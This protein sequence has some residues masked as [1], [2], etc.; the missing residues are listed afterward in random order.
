M[1]KTVYKGNDP[2]AI[3]C[4]AIANNAIFGF[5]WFYAAIL[6]KSKESIAKAMRVFVDP[7]NFP[8]LI[9]CVHGKD[10]TGLVVMLLLSLCGVPKVPIMTDYAESDRQLKKGKQAN[11]LQMAGEHCRF[12]HWRMYCSRVHG[13][14][15]ES[16][17]KCNTYPI[18]ATSIIVWFLQFK[19]SNVWPIQC[20]SM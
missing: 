7:C 4:P 20:G 5:K 10:R 6:D 15:I 19:L 18:P 11:E 12:M 14:I 16:W 8:I 2:A 13:T 17:I 9:H 3:M 1:A